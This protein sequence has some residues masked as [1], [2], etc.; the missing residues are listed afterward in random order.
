MAGVLAVTAVVVAAK[1]ALVVPAATAT[2]A[3][4]VADA[5]E[6]D[7]VTTAPPTGAGPLSVTVPVDVAPPTR[8]AGARASAD[9]AGELMVSTAVCVAPP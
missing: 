3:G 1:V 8:V 7:S 5:L 4:A 6:L 9:T 2:L